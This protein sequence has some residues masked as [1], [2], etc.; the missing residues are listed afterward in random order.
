MTG[1]MTSFEH[2]Q[3]ESGET[4][5]IQDILIKLFQGEKSDELSAQIKQARTQ[6]LWRTASLQE[7][8][9]ALANYL[10]KGEFEP[11]DIRQLEKGAIL[12]ET[13]SHALEKQI[14]E[15]LENGH[16][17]LVYLYLGWSQGDEELLQ[18]GLKIAAF[19]LSLC[20]HEGKLF[21]GMWIKEKEYKPTELSAVFTLLFSIISYCKAAPHPLHEDYQASPFISL[22]A[23]QFQKLI[24]KE[25]S[26]PDAK[27]ELLSPNLDR[28]L[29]FLRYH[30]GEMSFA[31]TASGFNTGLGSLHKKGIHIVSFGPHDAPL[32]DSDHYGIFR[33]SNGSAEG[34]KDLTLESSKLKGWTQ[35]LSRQW[36]FFEMK[37]EEE[38]F[39][40]T[41]R[42]SHEKRIYF[43]F[44]ISADGAHVGEECHLAPKALERYRGKNGTV[45]FTREGEEVTLVPHFEGE[46]EVIPLAGKAHF[47]SAEFLIAF[48]LGEKM[49]PYAWT[50][51]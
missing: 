20:D 40:L 18:A 4:F 24:D 16:I 11:L 21:Q 9:L 46:M 6:G 15:P 14:P 44:F 7:A 1:L 23:A 41:I 5:F 39:E 48:P 45:L 10:L 37:G 12:Q 47:W 50:V 51:K 27:L 2:V 32:A 34:F 19:C 17:A 25:V 8:Y 31:A 29:G 33:P 22:F 28:S 38:N 42:H 30:H 35:T 43:A 26:L 13:G 49:K 3:E 36:L